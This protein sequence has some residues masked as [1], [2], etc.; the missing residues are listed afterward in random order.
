MRLWEVGSGMVS[1]VKG[2]A[3]LDRLTGLYPYYS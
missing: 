2:K 1:Q 3:R